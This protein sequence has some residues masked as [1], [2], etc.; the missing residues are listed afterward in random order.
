MPTNEQKKSVDVNK[1][2]ELPA[3]VRNNRV[4]ITLSDEEQVELQ[5]RAG[6]KPLSEYVR[7][8]GLGFKADGRVEKDEHSVTESR[9]TTDTEQ[10]R[11]A[12]EVEEHKPE[13]S[14]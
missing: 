6:D 3:L 11:A 8:H 1:K 10:P 14:Q 4:V 12:K 2:P 5:K 13:S 7:E 9:P